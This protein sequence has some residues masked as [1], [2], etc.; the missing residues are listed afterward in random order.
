MR[1]Y[2]I[3]RAQFL[4]LCAS[5]LVLNMAGAQSASASCK[6][7]IKNSLML[8]YD[9]W[10]KTRGLDKD[11]GFSM[12]VQFDGKTILFDCG[13]DETIMLNNLKKSGVAIG[14][15]DFIVLS[16]PHP[17]HIGGL[18]AV[19]ERNRNIGVYASWFTRHGGNHHEWDMPE[20]QK[21]TIL[22]TEKPT[23][24]TPNIILITQHAPEGPGYFGVRET[25]IV[26]KTSEGL[27]IL[28]G[29]NHPDL[30]STLRKSMEIS[31]DNRIYMVAGGLHLIVGMMYVDGWSIPGKF[32]DI[33]VLEGIVEKTFSMGVKHILPAHDTGKEATNLFRKKWGDGFIEPNLGM[34]LELP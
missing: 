1:Q 30:E 13:T 15:I 14:D 19:L 17:D 9:Y 5:L 34:K 6:K 20:I 29:C 24:I 11:W 26:L 27:V 4:R 3:T 31:N 10:G 21:M 12:L 22:N 25:H 8:I 2:N 16:H 32:S 33:K 7:D 23:S 28:T 18:D